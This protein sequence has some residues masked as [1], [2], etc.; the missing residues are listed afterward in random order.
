MTTETEDNGH[1]DE[2]L[3]QFD[4]WAGKTR[5]GRE[6]TLRDFEF[7][8]EAIGGLSLESFA[9]LSPA[10]GARRM[11]RYF[12]AGLEAP[13]ED[14]VLIKVYEF[15]SVLD[16][17]H[18][19][20]QAVATYMAPWLPRCETKGLEL[21]DICFCGHDDL[22]TSVIFA[23]NNILAEVKS[24]GFNRRPVDE[25]AAELDRRMNAD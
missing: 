23:R 5:S 12:F 11:I 7:D 1:P 13:A 16:A 25:I 3:F 18:G 4:E 22:A 6:V 2:D 15:S 8:A 19:L 9:E 17:H 14:R 24:I 20:M 10:F 21:G